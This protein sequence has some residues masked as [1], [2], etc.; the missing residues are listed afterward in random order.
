[1]IK[2]EKNGTLWYK[3]IIRKVSKVFTA[4]YEVLY[5][6]AKVRAYQEKN[7]EYKNE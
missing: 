1:M 7:Q 4:I 6:E 5:L 3:S 2:K